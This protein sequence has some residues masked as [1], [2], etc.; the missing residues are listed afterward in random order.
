MS[1]LQRLSRTA[2]GGHAGLFI[3]P[4]YARLVNGEPFIKRVVPL[5]II[6]FVVALGIMRGV[7]L[8]QA[9]GEAEVN[10]EL[11]ISLLAKAVARDMMDASAPA[12]LAAPTEALQGQL[13]NALPPRATGKGRTI[14]VMDP[15]GYILRSRRARPELVGKHLDTVLGAAQP[16]T[17]LG[18]Q[19]GVLPLTWNPART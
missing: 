18:E 10:A 15:Q 19:A 6:L 13:E 8:V 17:T 2:L 3:H 11:R 16:L 7:A 12:S 14:L 4:A 5:L 1:D 9:R